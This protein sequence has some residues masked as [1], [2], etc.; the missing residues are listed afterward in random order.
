L[1]GTIEPQGAKNEALQILCAVLLTA[2]PV[3]ISNVPD[4]VD[5]NKLLDILESLGVRI[6]KK[7]NNHYLFQADQ[8]NLEYL[9]SDA[10]KTDGRKIRGSIMLV[11]P[12]LTR[13]GKG[14][15]P[16]TRWR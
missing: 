16:R 14:Y 11:G 12:L 1:S 13:F 15:I 7:G 8:V 4:I 10:F 9:K 6:E 5:I 2:E 3:E